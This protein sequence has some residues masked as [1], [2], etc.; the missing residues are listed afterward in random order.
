MPGRLP[1][2]AWLEGVRPCIHCLN[3]FFICL[4][5]GG[6]HCG[7]HEVCSMAHVLPASS[8]SQG[9]PV[10]PMAVHLPQPHRQLVAPATTA[11]ISSRVQQLQRQAP[12][13]WL[14]GVDLCD[15]QLALLLWCGLRQVEPVE[16][17]LDGP[18][19]LKLAVGCGPHFVVCG[20]KGAQVQAAGNAATAKRIALTCGRGINSR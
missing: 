19:G 7:A 10:K 8:S 15:H 2:L 18:D 14:G 12:N 13:A 9:A 3:R 4:Q 6:K 1:L 11:I 5:H 16:A 17:P 20:T